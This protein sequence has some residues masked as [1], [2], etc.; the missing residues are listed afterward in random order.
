M[1]RQTLVI[2]DKSVYNMYMMYWNPT[3]LARYAEF[4]LQ[5]RTEEERAQLVPM[6]ESLWE[7]VLEKLNTGE[8]HLENDPATNQPIAV[9]NPEPTEN[10]KLRWEMQ[11]KE[12]H[13]RTTSDDVLDAL[14]RVV[15]PDTLN[16]T[17]ES[18]TDTIE[19]AISLIQDRI[20][21]QNRIKEIKEIIGIE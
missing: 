18:S 6:E 2:Y 4:Q 10:D 1:R 9:A 7:D 8:Y 16:E 17:G 21:T 5:Y 19:K 15:M 3:T 20:D 13:L 12:E 14:I 11:E